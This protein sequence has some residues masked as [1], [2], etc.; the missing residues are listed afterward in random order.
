MFLSGY[1]SHENL[2]RTNESSFQPK[3]PLQQPCNEDI[4]RIFESFAVSE[5]KSKQ[6][7]AESQVKGKQKS[8]KGVQLNT[9]SKLQILKLTQYFC[10][11][12]GKKL[13]PYDV[14]ELAA[15]I[16][17][18]EYKTYKWL[19]DRRHLNERRQEKKILKR[20]RKREKIFKVTRVTC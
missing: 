3:F 15:S 9:K 11:N 19:W 13:R 8:R 10:E 2:T 14:R 5:L 6:H 7:F 1:L 18:S 20:L 12:M 17:L 16:G 4:E